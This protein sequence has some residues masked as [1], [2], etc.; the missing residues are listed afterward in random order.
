MIQ[1]L[2]SQLKENEKPYK[3]SLSSQTRSLA[4]PIALAM[5]MIALAVISSIWFNLASGLENGL[6]IAKSIMNKVTGIS[7]NTELIQRDQQMP[8][9]SISVLPTEI[10]KIYDQAME[11][12]QSRRYDSAIE[13]FRRILE[14]PPFHDLKDNA[15]YWLAECYFAKGEYDEALAEFKKVKESFPGGNK[16]FDSEVMVAYTYC[17]LG[18]IK[19]AKYKLYQLSVDFP[20]EGHQ[21]NISD[22]SRKIRSME[23]RG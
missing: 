6:D 13:K 11:D 15:Q 2:E 10:S 12:C 20:D 22:L 18:R 9:G 14:H 3:K 17:R 1:R 7:N 16:T 5:I 23:N 8:Y 21:S 19:Q 4:R